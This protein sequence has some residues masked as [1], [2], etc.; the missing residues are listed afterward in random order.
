VITE[1]E[2]A[3]S[4]DEDGGRGRDGQGGGDGQ[5]TGGNGGGSGDRRGEVPD[6][7]GDLAGGVERPGA[8]GRRD[9]NDGR[10]PWL[11]AAGGA[12]A[13]SAALLASGVGPHQEDPPDLHGYR[14]S[15]GPCAGGTFAPLAKAVNGSDGSPTLP[16]VTHGSAIDRAQCSFAV[17]TAAARNWT[18]TYVV[19]LTVALYK[20]ADPRPEFEND[21]RSDATLAVA[22]STTEVPHL[23]DKAYALSFNDQSQDLKVLYGGAVIYLSL[24]DSTFWTGAD[25]SPGAGDLTPSSAGLQT[26]TPALAD[27]AR[28]VMAALRH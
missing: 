3:W 17:N 9:R 13:A 20:V 24:S 22:D 14:I 18:T 4:G 12:A 21:R 10:L 5:D 28:A 2:I 26:F 23:G 27:T 6:V 15:A 8:G 1:P 19:N 16:S 11:W 7:I 25:R